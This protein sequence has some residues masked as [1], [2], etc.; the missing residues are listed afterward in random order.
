MQSLYERLGWQDIV[1]GY[2]DGIDV[3]VMRTFLRTTHAALTRWPDP[4][5]GL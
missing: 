5:I 3:T 4:L 2:Y 1:A